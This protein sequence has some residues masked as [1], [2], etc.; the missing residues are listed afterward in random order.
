MARSVTEALS[1]DESSGRRYVTEV[2]WS[3]MGNNK[4]VTAWGNGRARSRHR[5]VTWAWLHNL[6]ECILGHGKLITTLMN[7]TF[8]NRLYKYICYAIRTCSCNRGV[9]RMPETCAV[10][11]KY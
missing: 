3:L 1:H 5:S 4:S 8:M 9:K 6:L 11:R 7:N 2:H 10:H